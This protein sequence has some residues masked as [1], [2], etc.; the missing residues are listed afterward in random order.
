MSEIMQTVGSRIRAVRNQCSM[1]QEELAEKATL[2]PTYIGQVERGEK[3]LT[4]TSLE[5]IVAAL[6]ITFT[7][8]FENMEVATSQRSV[9]SQ[10]Y[11]IV[12]RKTAENQEKIL[13]ILLQI[14]SMT[15]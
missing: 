14:D 5:K 13:D 8:L 15:K 12:S 10:C 7:D 1:T 11:E 3:N 9:A 4:L 2:H 6:G